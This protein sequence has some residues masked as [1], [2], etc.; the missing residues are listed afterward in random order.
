MTVFLDV[1]RRI[2]VV[3]LDAR[4]MRSLE[5]DEGHGQVVALL[6]R[7]AAAK[8]RQSLAFLLRPVV[9]VGLIGT[10]YRLIPV[11]A[12]DA[13]VGD[14]LHRVPNVIVIMDRA[15]LRFR[16]RRLPCGFTEMEEGWVEEVFLGFRA[17]LEKRSQPLPEC[18]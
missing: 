13:V 17:R 12:P 15:R 18:R 8:V 11:V 6:K 9:T 10:R 5:R 4:H 2:L 16:P 7:R 3:R 1:L 14:L